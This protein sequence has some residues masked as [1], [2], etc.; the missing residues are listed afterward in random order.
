MASERLCYD[1]IEYSQIYLNNELLNSEQKKNLFNMPFN[2]FVEFLVSTGLITE[3]LKSNIIKINDVRNR[4]IHPKFEKDIPAYD[5]KVSLNLL[6]KIIDSLII[7][8]K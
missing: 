2:K 6:C 7:I 8:K 1:L 4:Y 5:A 3:E